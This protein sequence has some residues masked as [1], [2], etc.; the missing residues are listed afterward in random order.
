MTTQYQNKSGRSGITNYEFVPGGINVT[1]KNSSQY[2]YPIEGNDIR[3]METMH[4][5]LEHGEYA[6]RLINARNPQFV[7]LSGPST[8]KMVDN[9]PY[10]PHAE[11]V[12]ARAVSRMTPI[13]EKFANLKQSAMNAATS[14]KNWVK[15]RTK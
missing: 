15:A 2:H 10:P 11:N 14:F 1:F 9:R 7:K 5:L 12:A 8:G 4:G 3:S 6:N 13:K